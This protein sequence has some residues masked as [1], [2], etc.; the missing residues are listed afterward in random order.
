MGQAGLQFVQQFEMTK[1]LEAFEKE[2][3]AVV[4][5]ARAGKKKRKE[6]SESE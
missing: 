6:D 4:E 2:L 1:V 3:I 5:E